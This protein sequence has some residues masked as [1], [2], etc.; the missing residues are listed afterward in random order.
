MVTSAPCPTDRVVV[1]W[2]V[3]GL[4]A[5]VATVERLARL[6]LAGRRHGYTLRLR[7]ASGELTEL[8]AM[9]GLHNVLHS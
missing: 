5:D 1:D 2:D 3:A 7:N 8:I 6:E 4:P 9:L